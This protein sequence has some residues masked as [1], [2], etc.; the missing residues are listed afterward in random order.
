LELA[1]SGSPDQLRQPSGM[2]P[3]RAALL[4]ELPAQ[5]KE[6]DAAGKRTL[7]AG[8]Y[9]RL[10]RLDLADGSPRGPEIAL[11]GAVRAVSSDGSTAIV[12]RTD[13]TNN[14]SSLPLIGIVTVSGKRNWESHSVPPRSLRFCDLDG[15][16]TPEV[17]DGADVLDGATGKVRWQ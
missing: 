17:M 11:A 16:G 8:L 5:L 14:G 4:A 6:V 2:I 7:L 3:D 9:R 12:Q 1:A 13:I 15:D 10:V